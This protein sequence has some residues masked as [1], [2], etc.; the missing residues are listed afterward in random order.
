MPGGRE[1]VGHRIRE[2]LG[3]EGEGCSR[4]R[5]DQ[6]SA[7]PF[8]GSS[9]RQ[10]ICRACFVLVGSEAL[11]ARVELVH[12]AH[13]ADLS[14]AVVGIDSAVM[15]TALIHE[16]QR[17]SGLALGVNSGRDGSPSVAASQNAGNS[18]ATC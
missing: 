17:K 18:F 11:R 3:P 12:G 10:L 7:P 14:S 5:G 1:D 2:G 4:L 9:I 6:R 16:R 15:G 8:Q 13:E